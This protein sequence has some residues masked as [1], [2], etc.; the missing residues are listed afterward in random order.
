MP[1]IR[2]Y[3]PFSKAEDIGPMWTLHKA[4]RAVV[5]TLLTHPMGW[6]LVANVDGEMACTQFCRTERSVFD[7]SEDWRKAWESKGWA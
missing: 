6:E 3:D 4:A 1:A 5:C 2:P 7:T